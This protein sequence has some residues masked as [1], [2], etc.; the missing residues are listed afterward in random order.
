MCVLRT[1]QCTPLIVRPRPRPLPLP[2]HTLQVCLCCPFGME[3]EPVSPKAVAAVDIVAQKG[4]GAR[5][6]RVIIA[7]KLRSHIK[8]SRWSPAFYLLNEQGVISQFKGARP[9]PQGMR[10]E[11]V[12][13]VLFLLFPETKCV[14]IISSSKWVP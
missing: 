14:D 10:P 4:H 8:G 3:E 11:R 13:P 5:G 12:A 6:E 2:G 9:P 7:S 1:G